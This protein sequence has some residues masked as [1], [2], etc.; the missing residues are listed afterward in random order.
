MDTRSRVQK[1]LAMEREDKRALKRL[2]DGKL[3][4][5]DK[6]MPDGGVAWTMLTRMAGP[7]KRRRRAASKRARKA[8]QRNRR[9]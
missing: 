4:D 5:S 3:L 9:R 7:E 1:F 2:E 6:R 8:R